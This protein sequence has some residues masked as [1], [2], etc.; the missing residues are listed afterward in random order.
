M[1]PK[2]NKKRE[3][4]FE[5]LLS[6]IGG[7]GHYNSCYNFYESGCWYGSIHDDDDDDDDS[8]GNGGSGIYIYREFIWNL[9]I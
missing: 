9:Y 3:T 7:I 6:A 2:R 5:E 1:D 8:N 4:Q